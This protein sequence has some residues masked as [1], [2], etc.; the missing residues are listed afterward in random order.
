M[1]YHYLGATGLKV[2]ALCLGS[3]TFGDD[4]DGASL[5]T[6]PKEIAIEMLDA[7]AD[8]GGNFID[9]ADMYTR[10]QAEEISTSSNP[11]SIRQSCSQFEFAGILILFTFSDSC[12]L[13]P[14]SWRVA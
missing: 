8:L 9:T 5:P 2:S 14:T 4:T 6:T 13:Y 10:G 1:Q 3:M 11:R 12:F 7:F